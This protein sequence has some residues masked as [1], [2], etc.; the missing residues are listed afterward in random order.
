MQ[1]R[2]NAVTAHLI[3]PVIGARFSMYLVNMDANATS[4]PPSSEVERFVF[5]L[6]GEL[7]AVAFDETLESG[8]STVV[9]TPD[10]FAYFPS[11]MR[12]ELTT[13]NSSMAALLV[14]EQVYQGAGQPQFL[15]GS[16]ADQAVLPVPGEVFL[17]R[18]LL[19]P[20]H[21]YDFNIHVM[22]RTQ[23]ATQEGTNL[24]RNWKKDAYNDIGSFSN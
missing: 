6:A 9:L 7:E 10:D 21:N 13:R 3:T 14:W 23:L 8:S 4:K 5:V 22:V 19:P 1:C 17:L 20:N 11:G 2:N 12:H 24:H 15:H 18:K 16:T